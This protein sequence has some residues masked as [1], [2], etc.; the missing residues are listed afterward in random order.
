MAKINVKMALLIVQIKNRFDSISRTVKYTFIWYNDIINWKY[1]LFK[2]FCF[3]KKYFL[4]FVMNFTETCDLIC[5]CLLL[6]LD[7]P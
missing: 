2:I 1:L 4:S 5:D 3:Y 7:L 6:G